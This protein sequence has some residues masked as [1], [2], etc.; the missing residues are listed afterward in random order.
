MK[1][2]LVYVLLGALICF[3]CV[4]FMGTSLSGQGNSASIATSDD[5]KF[6]YVIGYQSNN[7]YRSEDFGKTFENLDIDPEE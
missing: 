1:Q 2:K 5:G 7:Y 3:S 6:V 4:S